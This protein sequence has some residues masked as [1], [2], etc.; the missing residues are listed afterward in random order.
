MKSDLSRYF[1]QMFFWS[2]GS[3]VLQG[4]HQVAK[5][6]IMIILPFDLLMSTVFPSI[7]VQTKDGALDPVLINVVGSVCASEKLT[8]TTRRDKMMEAFFMIE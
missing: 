5:K 2:T 7:V 8:V 6:L 1:S 4:P 3:S